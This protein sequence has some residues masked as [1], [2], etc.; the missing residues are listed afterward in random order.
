MRRTKINS[1]E[2]QNESIQ[3]ERVVCEISVHPIQASIIKKLQTGDLDFKKYSLRS[4]AK[5]IGIEGA[6]P[7]K[8]KHHLEQLVTWGIIHKMYGEYVYIKPE[9]NGNQ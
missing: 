7:Q 3:K 8:I 1:K 5:T 6:S 4:V 2:N 9:S